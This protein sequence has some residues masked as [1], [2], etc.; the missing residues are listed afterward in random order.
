M[1]LTWLKL[2]KKQPIF[3]R[4]NH[5]CSWKNQPVCDHYGKKTSKTLLEI[6]KKQKQKQKNNMLCRCV[7]QSLFLDI[8]GVFIQHIHSLE[9]DEIKMLDNN[10]KANGGGGGGRINCW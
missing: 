2:K 6:E 9:R 8:A 7:Y 4:K 3:V 5:W 1:I 10:I